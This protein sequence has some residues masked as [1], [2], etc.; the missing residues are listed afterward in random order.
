[1]TVRDFQ[2]LIERIYYGKDSGRGLE[3]S[4][5]WFVEEV[6]ELSRG[7]RRDGHQELAGEFA[8]V[9]AWLFTLASIAGVDMEEAVQT[10]YGGG[11]PKCRRAPC[12]CPPR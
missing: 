9:A 3:G 2:Q 11:C 8:D 7:L 6:G 5:M 12:E 4:F 1:M 10:K